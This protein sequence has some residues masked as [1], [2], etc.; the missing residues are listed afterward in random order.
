MLRHSLVLLVEI[1][2]FLLGA[3]LLIS[4][5]LVWRL[6][7][8]PIDIDF[9]APYVEQMATDD[10]YQLD[11]GQ[12][13]LNWGGTGSP[14]AIT[15]SD[16]VV[17][18]V[19]EEDGRRRPIVRLPEAELDLAWAPLLRGEVITSRL[20]LLSPSLWAVR[21]ADGGL[22]VGFTND[23]PEAPNGVEGQDAAEQ[24][25]PVEQP[26]AP[27]DPVLAQQTEAI[28]P[29][30]AVLDDVMGQG[31]ASDAVMRLVEALLGPPERG[32]R[33]T[34][35]QIDIADGRLVLIDRRT[36]R[37]WRGEGLDASITRQV[38][39]ITA[40]FEGTVDSPQ[41]GSI[42][43]AQGSFTYALATGTSEVQLILDGIDT[44]AVAKALMRESGLPTINVPVKGVVSA[45]FD[46]SFILTDARFDVEAASGAI[47]FG[48]ALPRPFGFDQLGVVG[49]FVAGQKRMEFDKISIAAD[50]M[51]LDLSGAVTQEDEDWNIAFGVTAEN[52]PTDRMEIYWPR[53][54]IRSVRN[55]VVVKTFGGQVDRL[56]A[57]GQMRISRDGSWRRQLVSLDGTFSASDVNLNPLLGLP[58]IRNMTGTA[59]FDLDGIH[60]SVPT[61]TTLDA[62]LSEGK[63]SITGFRERPQNVDIEFI[64]AGSLATGIYYLNRPRLRLIER[65]GIPTEGSDGRTAGRVR[66]R[67]PI[68]GGLDFND[69]SAIAAVNIRDGTLQ[70]TPRWQL[71]ETS[72]TLSVDQNSINL[73]GNGLFD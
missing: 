21:Q 8:G 6:S 2:A 48:E 62:A 31:A 61:A 9:L 45:D 22:G 56:E 49:H 19:N 32:G 38:S 47:D 16:V 65:L 40:V 54:F 7:Q 30:E 23:P 44:T 12:T 34:L 15:A 68:K 67:F 60:F 24:S 39:A 3:L 25:E 5:V 72:A 41:V 11:I 1:G 37:V 59:R 55:W 52:A 35:S 20:R 58:P 63:I 13:R 27:D 50:P 14:L 66:L 73:D 4:L 10:P 46:S 17:F 28:E 42:G 51:T 70:L 33:A 18:E 36:D 64:A 69:I 57:A 71:T 26:E 29:P 43:F 53:Q